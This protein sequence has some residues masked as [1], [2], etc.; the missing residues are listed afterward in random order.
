MKKI[1]SIILVLAITLSISPA[2][3]AE[4][5]GIL[6]RADVMKMSAE[7]FSA[8][9]EKAAEDS[10][11]EAELMAAT[12]GTCGEILTWV[13]SE[14]GT[15]TISG[16]GD[17]SNWGETY[18]APWR[19]NSETI[20]SVV[21]GEEVTRIG[22]RAFAYCSKLTNMTIPDSVTSIGNYAFEYC[23]GLTSVTISGSVTSIGSSAF[24]SCSGLT[25]LTIPDG[26]TSIGSN[27]FGGCSGLT[28]VTI[29]DSVTSIGNDA[30]IGC[31]SLTSVIIP[32]SV[33][34]IGND[35]FRNCSSLT[36][37]TIPD[38]VTSIGD[39][40]FRSCYNLESIT[41]PDS[42][43]Y[44]GFYAFYSCTRL[45]SVKIGAGVT[46][47]EYGVFEECK[48]LESIT[49]PDSVTDLGWYMFK[50][51]SSLTSATIGNGVTSIGGS[52]FFNCKSLKSVTIPESVTGIWSNAFSNCSSLTSVTIPDGVTTIDHDAFS[53]CSSLTSVVIP[54]SVTSIGN[55]AFY[56]CS[57]L[58]SATI[59][60]GVT[61]IGDNAF[62]GCSGLTS[63]T[64]PNKVTTIGNYAFQNCSGLKSVAISSGVT[65][66]G[67]GA[68][69]NCDGLTSVTIPNKVTTMGNYAFE[70]CNGLTSVT[71]LSGATSIG[72]GAFYNCTSLASVT[73]PGSVTSIGQDAFYNCAFKTAGS[74][75]GGYDFEF[76]WTE[77]IPSNA[78]YNCTSLTSVDI[79]DGVTSIGDNAF[80]KCGKLSNVLIPSSVK[81]IDYY[82]FRYCTALTEVKIPEGVET[83]N[84]S[85][86]EDCSG[87]VSVSLPESLS[88]L[89][90]YNF[91]NCSKLA[92]VNI[93]SGITSIGK[94]VFYNCRSLASIDIPDG[95]TSIGENAFYGDTALESIKL[96]KAIETLGR[97]AFNGCVKIT[98]IEIPKGLLTATYG[99]GATGS[100]N[101]GV[102]AGSGIKIVSFEKGITTIPGDIFA[103]C[104]EL[105]SIIVPDTVT[106]ILTGAFQFCTS[107]KN[108]TLPESVTLM[109]NY[110]FRRCESLTSVDLPD[111]IKSLGTYA[112]AECSSLKE[113]EIP[114][115][116]TSI[117]HY[118][119]YNCTSLTGVTIPGSVTSIGDRAFSGCSKLTSVTLPDGVTSLGDSVFFGC[120]SLTSVTIPDSVTSMGS[121]MFSGCSSLTS[122]IIPEGVTG[123]PWDMFYGCSSLKSVKI[124]ESVTN[125]GGGAFEG[126]GELVLMVFPDSY[127]EKYAIE[128][129]LKY[130][131]ITYDGSS[132]EV[133]LLTDEGE[134]LTN[135]C[136]I[137]WYEG[138]S[139]IGTGNKLAYPEGA[140]AIRFEIE[141][142]E[143]NSFI[144]YK[145]EGQ[146]VESGV[147][148]VKL[149]KI[150]SIPLT[151]K[152]ADSEG[153]PL[154]EAEVLITQSAGSY[155]RKINVKTDKNGNYSASILSLPTRAEIYAD[156]YY[157]MAIT[158]IRSGEKPEKVEAENISAL[159]IP[160]NKITYKIKLTYAAKEGE[161]GHTA[162]VTGVNTLVFKVHNDTKNK[163]ITDFTVQYP[164]IILGEGEA[165]GNDKIT[166]STS[167]PSKSTTATDAAVTL[168]GQLMGEAE[169]ELLQ[170]GHIEAKL[171]GD[172][173][174]LVMIFDE[175][176]KLLKNYVT[177]DMSFSSDTLQQGEYKAVF[178]MKTSLLTSVGRIEKLKDLGLS[179]ESDYIAKDIQVKNGIISDAGSI[180]VPT[181]DESKLYYTDSEGTSV[182]ANKSNTVAGQLVRIRAEYKIMDKY[183]A[184]GQCVVIE[185]PENAHFVENSVTLNGKAA[186]YTVGEN[187]VTVYTNE[188]S[189]VVRC[190]VTAKE[191]ADYG[192]GAYLSFEA[193]GDS[194]MQ[195]IGTAYFTASA[196]TISAPK[197]T[198]QE[199]VTVSGKALVGST[200][201]V[202]DNNIEVGTAKAN[203]EGSWALSL[204]LIRPYSLSYHEVYAVVD[205]VYGAH[206]VSDAA[207]IIHDKTCSELTK[208]TMINTAHPAG[209]LVP[210]ECVCVF[211]FI[212]PATEAP[213]Y[214]YWP[215]YPTFTFIVEINESSPGAVSDVYV[216]T[217]NSSGEQTY[218]LCEYD[219]ESE[220]WIGTQ[221]YNA[222]NI[223][224]YVS[225]AYNCDDGTGEKIFS[226]DDI[227]DFVVDMID[228]SKD[229][230][231]IVEAEISAEEICNEEDRCGIRLG[232]YSS[233]GKFVPIAEAYAEAVDYSTF[234]LDEWAENG[235]SEITLE[236]GTKYYMTIRYGVDSCEYLYASPEDE[237]LLKITL[238]FSLG[239]SGEETA[240]LMD[241]ENDMA[242]FAD[243]TNS[244]A[245][246][247]DGWPGILAGGIN[248]IAETHNLNKQIEGNSDIL[249]LA[250]HDVYSMIFAKCKGTQN[251]RLTPAEKVKFLNDYNKNVDEVSNYQLNM[252][253]TMVAR[254]GI[255]AL[256]TFGTDKLNNMAADALKKQ[257]KMFQN[258]AGGK[259]AGVVYKNKNPN[260]F[261]GEDS[262]DLSDD[263]A[264]E[265]AG[266]VVGN[267]IDKIE[268]ALSG[269]IPALNTA[270]Y[271]ED[272]YNRVHTNLQATQ[273]EIMNSY[274]DCSKPNPGGGPTGGPT[275]GPGGGPTGGPGGG[276]NGGPG[277]GPTGGP[278]GG[279]GGGP[280][281]GPTGG[282]GA[283]GQPVNS[284]IDPSGYVCEAVPSNRIG[285][286]T[287][288]LYYKG[289]VLDDFGEPTGEKE[290]VLWDAS[291]YDQENPLTTDA[292]GVYAWD[293]PEG[294]WQVKYEKKD[295]NTAYSDWM[296]VPPP[297]TEV[298]IGLISTLAPEVETVSAYGDNI[299]IT[300]SQYM[301]PE[302]VNGE[303]V[304]VTIDGK[305]ITGEIEAYDAET[306]Y[307]DESVQYARTFVFVP[308]NE[309]SGSAS[310]SVSGAINYAGTAMEE[311]YRGVSIVVIEPKLI[312]APEKVSVA[313]KSGALAEISILPKEAAKDLKIVAISSSP[314]IVSVVNDV[315]EADE[316]GK[317]N[318][319]LSGNLPGSGV[320]T[321]NV[322]GT[323]ITTTITVDV[324]GVVVPEGKKC[325]KVTASI[326]SGSAV[327]KGTKLELSTATEGAEIY[328]TLD[329]TCPCTV[330]SPSRL[331]YTDPIVLNEDTF[332]IAYAVKDGYEDSATAGF[333]YTVEESGAPTLRVHVN[334]ITNTSHKIIAA[335]Y[336]EDGRMLKCVTATP[337]GTGED[338][339]EFKSFVAETVYLKIM[340][341]DSVSGMKPARQV[342]VKKLVVQE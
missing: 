220:H 123:I 211:D 325:A 289:D 151:G 232:G 71:I 59:L 290:A 114:S 158:L 20:T 159:K 284:G 205:T 53:G 225:A 74:I 277:G 18:G 329:G 169:I 274:D 26:V 323:D 281:G 298:N 166:I 89:G 165:D 109:D 42:V 160:T 261:L 314:S 44:M 132:A 193:D 227:G 138:D 163:D 257:F 236:D 321:L 184:A 307:E 243:F 127:A 240:Q 6:K 222:E 337:S 10:A 157:K 14:N 119:F 296:P 167:D 285:G 342:T 338:I 108:V 320:V 336:S 202:F 62:Y 209:A 65:S 40:A 113:L 43:T 107:L 31:S 286:V 88:Y 288:T 23:R 244:V 137:N 271:I 327:A 310:V 335:L 255:N 218:I 171:V 25:S 27:A 316:N 190:Y 233:E 90:S 47:M 319:M 262:I 97:N 172:G 69:Y 223:P 66:I 129:S 200:V 300:F 260:N 136:T 246:D 254:L 283:G 217:T 174:K 50:N 139:L 287:T 334:G 212:N 275:G 186:G 80:Y 176:G 64:I 198:A 9:E 60:D 291:E 195:P 101:E 34:S 230:T 312:E 242:D 181:L 187:S 279:P 251:D 214:W 326:D 168:D 226:K 297:Q 183:S 135:G 301:K 304:K 247:L 13:V 98:E 317:A 264:D 146:T 256:K 103:G 46:K 133:K 63:V 77:N 28:S 208:I 234:N 179:E 125:I 237:S 332:I 241:L 199:K 215:N 162:E 248:Q 68:F 115:G 1:I 302:T 330:D 309:I 52:L 106:R 175:S 16:T 45:K 21:I 253:K 333:T 148:E 239:N 120:S 305:E 280:T 204:N 258:M 231:S 276:L 313:Y 130:E 91:K 19:R 173:A 263:F 192:V 238:D 38:S 11:G 57:G 216:I 267:G 282:P 142:S 191:A 252:Q 229:I 197:R 196:M 4:G 72:S 210:S 156:G 49:I 61:S 86:F 144:Y 99:A 154:A 8:P 87:L 78:F 303:T 268:N 140:S 75:G 82:A 32:D 272:E 265:F 341:W 143:E 185:L 182:T 299:K 266:E 29:S 141:L 170:N 161:E 245:Q 155:E 201:K 177:E 39:E 36:S 100:I 278:T 131:Y 269:V 126:C 3:L 81:T 273:K 311:A 102:F 51:C 83:M 147:Y 116:V 118:A 22:D 295:Y 207:K 54:D 5:M 24:G 259:N 85:V 122:V 110:V 35:V 194:V 228:L 128:N 249:E 270:D 224:A 104:T 293:V 30:F 152:V 308:E 15:L 188:K 93:P 339:I 150:P 70:N 7:M 95:V 221:N 37:V 48:S 322:L 203:A 331:K 58:T 250:N 178:M 213:T 164:Y 112:F 94:E 117:G 189:A 180:S 56:G 134:V 33:T 292:N 340:E 219:A 206:V 153:Q 328:Y 324:G 92:S 294:Q 124:P 306:S 235:Y 111:G 96:P 41:I 315:I 76:G 121:S 17:M 2:A 79:P 318:I 149:E 12:S 73:I 67:N 105:E 145:P 84:Y 55:S